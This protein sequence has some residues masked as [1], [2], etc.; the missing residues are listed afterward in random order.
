MVLSSDNYS[1]VVDDVTKEVI[2]FFYRNNCPQ[3]EGLLKPYEKVAKKFTSD[4]SI[5]FAKINLSENDLT[6]SQST[7]NIKFYTSHFKSGFEFNDKIENLPFFVLD[8]RSMD[9][10]K[11]SRDSYSIVDDL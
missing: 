9:K 5:I 2:V 4:N 7:P 1:K 10:S 11:N 8:Y 6:F 3:C